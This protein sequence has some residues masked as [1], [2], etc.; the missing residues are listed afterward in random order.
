MKLHVY[1]VST[2]HQGTRYFQMGSEAIEWAQSLVDCEEQEIL[3]V[4]KCEV[5]DLPIG[6]L[7]PKLLNGQGWAKDIRSLGTV[8]KTKPFEK[9]S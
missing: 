2:D 3:E 7:I 4:E 1:S 5:L 6:E 8:R 9:I